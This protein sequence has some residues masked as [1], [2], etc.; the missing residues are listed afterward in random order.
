MFHGTSVI[1]FSW[2]IEEVDCHYNESFLHG[3]SCQ[4]TYFLSS[5]GFQAVV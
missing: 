3:G 5:F 1:F 2:T 4:N